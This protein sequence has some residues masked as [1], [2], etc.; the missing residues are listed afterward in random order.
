TISQDNIEWHAKN[1]KCS[2]EEIIQ[3]WEEAPEA[4]VV[5]ANFLSYLRK[6]NPQNKKFAA[7]ISA[8]HNIIRFDS[9]I[10][11]RMR[12]EYSPKQTVIFHPRDFIDTMNLCY[13][14]FESLS[15]P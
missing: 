14:W 3:S 10:L 15:Q 12:K 4:N 7:P 13:L 6:F 5:W 9:I 8:G 1:R 2:P 11:E